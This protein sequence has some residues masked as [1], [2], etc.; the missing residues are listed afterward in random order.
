MEKKTTRGKKAWLVTRHWIADHPKWEVAAI[1]N[2]RISGRRVREFL[3]LIELTSG[4]LTLDE[5]LSISWPGRRRMP[6]RAT[7]GL[8]T[9]GDPWDGEVL[10]GNDPYLRAR[11][12]DDLIIERNADGKEIAV[13]KERPRSQGAEGISHE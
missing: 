10:C 3:D 5:Q 2:P 4:S 1:F 12:V 13:W 7:L 11:L 9:K 6:Y 8:T